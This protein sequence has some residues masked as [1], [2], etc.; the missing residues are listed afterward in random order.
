M[1]V[2]TIAMVL[3]GESGVTEVGTCFVARTDT[4]RTVHGQVGCLVSRDLAH[5]A[6]SWAIPV[7][8]VGIG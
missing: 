7:L 1:S 4:G 2:R 5:R 8:R 6:C 3:F